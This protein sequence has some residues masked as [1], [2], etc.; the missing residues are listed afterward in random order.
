MVGPQTSRVGVAS[1]TE[2]W[3]KH[4]DCQ[5]RDQTKHRHSRHQHRDECRSLRGEFKVGI[6]CFGGELVIG[7]WNGLFDITTP[8]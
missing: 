1:I 4:N 7:D 6:G 3:P 2:H 5:T 8:N